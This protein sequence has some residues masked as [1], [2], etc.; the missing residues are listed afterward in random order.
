MT[1]LQGIEELNEVFND[2]FAMLGY[3]EIECE[4]NIDFSYYYGADIIT[5][6]LFENPLSDIG[7]MTY[8]HNTF[9][10]V[11]PCSTMVLSLLH[12]LG[13]HVTMPSIKRKKWLKCK[14]DKRRLE[15]VKTNTNKARIE[16]QIKYSSLFDEY[17]ATKK[18]I[19]IL[20]N[21]YDL[22]LSFESVW[23]N[24]VMEFYKKNNVINT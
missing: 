14:K 16:K 8:I 1:K 11:P 7:F 6:T 22:I 2:F 17:I 5:Y 4:L 19:E 12:E 23:Y 10:N 18:A 15:R 24:A 13:H 21:N 20:N 3:E 9:K